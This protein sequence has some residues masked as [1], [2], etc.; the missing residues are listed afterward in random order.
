METRKFRDIEPYQ[1]FQRARHEGETFTQ[2]FNGGR[3][4]ERQRK[5]RKTEREREFL[6]LKDISLA[7]PST[8][9]QS[10]PP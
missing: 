6:T 5:Q 8:I 9:W 10:S 3:G 2:F 4:V 7:L 1:G